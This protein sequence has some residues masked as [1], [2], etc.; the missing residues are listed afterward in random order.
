M[1]IECKSRKTHVS[2]LMCLCLVE[3]IRSVSNS[4]P[5]QLSSKEEGKWEAS[6][7]QQRGSHLV[8][9]EEEASYED[10]V[11]LTDLK[12]RVLSSVRGTAW[13]EVKGQEN[14]WEVIQDGWTT[15][16]TSG[17]WA[18][19]GGH[20]WKIDWDH[21]MESLECW[22]ERFVFAEWISRRYLEVAPRILLILKRECQ[23][24]WLKALYLCIISSLS[25][26]QTLPCFFFF[27]LLGCF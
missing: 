24:T 5:Q 1:I 27:F 9:G 25:K 10:V 15:E 22:L 26:N 8:L 14:A 20:M 4:R 18:W 6:E 13:A 11:F 19:T 12:R 16:L 3:G 2:M 23:T 21:L 17:R 7:I